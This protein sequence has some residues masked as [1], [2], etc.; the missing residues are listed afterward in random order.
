MNSKPVVHIILALQHY[1][2]LADL[3]PVLR[4][5]RPPVVII[6]GL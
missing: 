6:S 2:R 1:A 5:A 3:L 4:K